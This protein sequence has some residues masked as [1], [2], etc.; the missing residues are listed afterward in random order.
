MLAVIRARFSD[1]SASAIWS[2]AA[3]HAW[4]DPNIPFSLAHYWTRTSFGGADMRYNL[5]PS[6]VVNDNRADASLGG[7]QRDRLVWAVLDEV[8]RAFDPDWDLFDQFLNKNWRLQGRIENLF[9]EHYQ[10]AAFFNQ[11]GRNFFAMVRYQP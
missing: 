5:F 11:P 4:F 6:V 1:T 3:M 2:D 8:T 7:D 9:N 10:T